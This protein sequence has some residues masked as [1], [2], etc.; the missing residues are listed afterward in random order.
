MVCGQYRI[1]RTVSHYAACLPFPTHQTRAPIL[2]MNTL[3]YTHCEISYA[4]CHPFPTHQTRALI[5]HPLVDIMCRGA[6]FFFDIE[7]SRRLSF[8]TLCEKSCTGACLILS[9]FSHP[10]GSHSPPLLD[11]MCRGS[12]YFI[13]IESP[14]RLS[15][16]NLCVISGAG[17]RLILSKLS[18]PA[19]SYVIHHPLWEIMCRGFSPSSA[20]AHPAHLS[21][22]YTVCLLVFWISSSI[23]I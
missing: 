11:I 22:F 23:C 9:T 12:P 16:T 20:Y 21:A 18:N 19:G 6:V 5:H 4:A 14:H 13:D 1:M 10:A 7:S 15:V 3:K 17:A 8:T 2:Y